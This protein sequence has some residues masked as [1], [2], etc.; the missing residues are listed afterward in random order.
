[1]Y[2]YEEL[3]NAKKYV[4]IKISD[5]ITSNLKYELFFWQKEALENLI[6]LEVI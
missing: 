6:L 3:N 5:Y 1:M 4:S 2:L